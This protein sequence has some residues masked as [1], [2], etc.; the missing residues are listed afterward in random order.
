MHGCLYMSSHMF[1][2]LSTCSTFKYQ[3]G[4]RRIMHAYKENVYYFLPLKSYKE[5]NGACVYHKTWLSVYAYENFFHICRITH[6]HN[7]DMLFPSFT[8]G[9]EIIQRS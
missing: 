7:G 5:N 2:Y 1:I 6:M 9:K 8:K 4:I 3:L